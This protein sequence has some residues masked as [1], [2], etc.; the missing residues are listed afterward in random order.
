MADH[1]V[2]DSPQDLFCYTSEDLKPEDLPSAPPLTVIVLKTLAAMVDFHS[3]QFIHLQRLTSRERLLLIRDQI[4]ANAL[5]GQASIWQKFQKYARLYQAQQWHA[6]LASPDQIYA[7]VLFLRHEGR[8]NVR[9]VGVYLSAISTVH[10]WVGINSFSMHNAITARLTATWKHAIPEKQYAPAN[11]D[12]PADDVFQMVSLGLNN[13]SP[14]RVRPFLSVVLDTLFFSRADSGFNI[15]VDDLWI[16]GH[17]LWFREHC[18]KGK[19]VHTLWWRTRAFDFRGIP[20]LPRLVAH[21]CRLRKASWVC[22]QGHPSGMLY[23]LPLD[24]RDPTASDVRHWFGV[25][26]AN[27]VIKNLTH[28]SV[29]RTGASSAFCILVPIQHIKDWGW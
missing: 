1:G 24:R 4:S 8:V 19:T 22:Q 18:F 13:S 25:A 20:D 27:L 2:E 14:Y 5:S 9:N 7:Y 23:R 16:E 3:S 21:F 11:R 6:I 28:H 15:A 17:F 29:W 10:T 12:F 26:R